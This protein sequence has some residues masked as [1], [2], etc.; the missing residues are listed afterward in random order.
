VNR[1]GNADMA[2]RVSE[3]IE[4]VEAT[5]PRSVRHVRFTLV[6]ALALV[7]GGSTPL[8]LTQGAGQTPAPAGAAPAQAGAGQAGRGAQTAAPGARAGGPGLSD[9]ANIGGDY[10]P[11]PPVLA[12]TPEEQAKR[13]ILPP[14]YRLELVLSE[15]D[16]INPAAMAFDGNGRLYI[17]EIR[18]YM[19][20]AD[21]GHQHEPTSRISMHESSKGDGVFD[22]HHVFADNLLFPRMVLPLDKSLL[23]N[24]THSDDVLKL[25]DTNGDGVADKREVFYTGVGAGRSGNVQQAQ[26]GFVW[27]LD[28]WIYSTYNA[29][30][31][32]W[33]PSGVVREPSGPPGAEWGMSMDD[34]GKIWLVNAAGER[35][36]ANFQIPIQYGAFMVNDQWEPG[37][38]IPYPAPSIGDMQGGLPRV[39]IP[40]NSL[41]HF[42]STTGPEIVRSDRYPEDL[43]GDLLFAD[44]VGRF[45]RRAKIV[46]TEGLTQVRNAYPG[47]EFIISTDPLFRP[48]NIKQGPDGAIYILDIYHGIIQDAN[49]TAKGTYLR[50]K[51]EQYQL[52]KVVGHGRVWR[53]RYDGIP[54]GV[55]EGAAGQPAV[56]AIPL[57]KT[58]PRMNEETAAQLVS[59]LS[60]PIAWWRDTTQKLLVLKQDKSIVPALQQMAQSSNSLVARFHALWTLEG[61]GALDAA[62]VREV[63]KDTNPRMRIQALRASESLYKAGNRTFA[64]DYRAMAEDSDVDVAIQAMLSLSAIKAPTLA[65]VVKSAQAANKARGIKEIGDF[66]VR[67]PAAAAAA[68][69]ATLSPEE[70]KQIEEGDGIYKSLC[71]SCHGEDG[72]GQPQVGG[73]PGAT[74]APSLAGSPRVNGH[75]DYVIKVLLKGLTGPIEATRSSSAEVM[76]PMGNNTDQWVASIGSYIRSSF[77]NAGGMVTAADVA[78]VRAATANRKAPWTLK[79]LEPTLPRR[80]EVTPAWKATASHNADTA[81]LAL[82]TR[83]WTSGAPQAPG[84]WFQIELPQPAAVTELEF[85]SPLPTGRGGGRG[86]G[87]GGGTPT[88]A[89]A[90]PF[91][92]GYRVE[93][94]MDGTN[95][96]KPVAEGKGVGA[97]TTIAFAPTRAK[98]VRI[99]QTDA[100]E[101]PPNWSMANVRVYEAGAGK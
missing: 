66:L 62:L 98:F 25:T 40:G 92:R 63:L 84:M 15:P 23:T 82:T 31:F 1:N 88:A 65:D 95:W 44:P 16:V 9:A 36:P 8:V 34:D 5:R 72:R 78:R 45:I 80:I 94:S 18:S 29:F 2:I 30:R 67:P 86:A 69:G 4:H 11:K 46:K 26:S 73:A 76:L 75:R 51:I 100:V 59:H 58:W 55:V 54:A 87:G 42:T 3:S 28:N 49:W 6:G 101:N 39:R 14:G 64:D 17:A 71:F 48:V 41:S 70:R 12:L 60:D 56:P 35:G 77:G 32:R 68:G 38:D 53:L 33:T 20:D 19:L 89:P 50:Y 57:G 99:T 52:D 37:F 13:F 93:A 90:V 47:S 81:A 21:A 61:L 22:K 24:E 97:H 83:S 43:N 79:E 27:S 7:V 91:L 96:G 74:L 10:G 85:D